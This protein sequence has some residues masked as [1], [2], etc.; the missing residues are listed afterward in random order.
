MLW[1]SDEGR[2]HLLHSFEAGLA[3]PVQGLQMLD[4]ACQ[5]HTYNL[6]LV[7]ISR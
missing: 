4:L 3:V 7:I 1:M 6:V 5:S 2:V